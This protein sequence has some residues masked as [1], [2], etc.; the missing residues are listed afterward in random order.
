[1][2]TD[3]P[4]L[5]RAICEVPDCD[6]RRLGYADHL[7]EMAT[8]VEC[9][10]Q[11]DPKR[12]LRFDRK[13][14][15]WVHG[16]DWCSGSGRVSDGRA[17]RASFI[18][19]Q[20]ELAG[21]GKCTIC[22]DHVEFYSP[23]MKG[24]KQRCWACGELRRRESEL[25]P[26]CPLWFEIGADVTEWSRGFVSGITW[27]TEQFMR[28]AAAIFA[29]QPVEAVT[30]NDIMPRRSV[31]FR[32]GDFTELDASYDLHY[33]FEGEVGYVPQLLFAVI[34]QQ[35]QHRII[36][37]YCLEFDTVDAARAALSAGAVALGRSLAH[38]PP[39]VTPAARPAR[40]G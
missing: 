37:R 39:L 23:D 28:H 19:V 1:M 40:V 17:E 32:E 30:F 14:E 21:Q 6:T 9:R 25:L 22:N 10:C 35:Y 31:P 13:K 15:R 36:N 24:G 12:N 18:R 38:L 29:A 11:G 5:L 3:E 34:R 33:E 20:V 26:L 16:C 8:E 4:L 7:D 27:N 2:T